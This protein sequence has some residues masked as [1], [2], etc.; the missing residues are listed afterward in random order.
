[1]VKKENVAFL[2]KLAPENA[3][4]LSQILIDRYGLGGNVPMSISAVAKKYGLLRETIRGLEGPMIK[5]IKEI[6]RKESEADQS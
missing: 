6:L 1:M 5:H 3:T 2:A 4:L